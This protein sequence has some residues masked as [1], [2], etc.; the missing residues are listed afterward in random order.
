M[1]A[2]MEKPTAA[3]EHPM[4]CFAA[5]AHSKL[6]GIQLHSELPQF[7]ACM[8][9]VHTCSRRPYLAACPEHH[10]LRCSFFHE[11]LAAC[12]KTWNSK[13]LLALGKLDLPKCSERRPIV[14]LRTR[15]DVWTFLR[16]VRV[17]MRKCWPSHD[18]VVEEVR[19]CDRI[20]R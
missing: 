4:L 16:S 11:A 17:L 5:S 3:Q 18:E 8:R 7:L 9:P 2:F 19:D 15:A 12:A 14:T 6:L 10:G 13:W 1:V 20:S